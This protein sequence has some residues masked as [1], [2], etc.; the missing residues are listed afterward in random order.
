[1]SKTYTD[2][3]LPV[4]SDDIVSVVPKMNYTNIADKSKQL[5]VSH[6]SRNTNSLPQEQSTGYQLIG[7]GAAPILHQ[8]MFVPPQFQQP[9]PSMQGKYAIDGL[10][11]QQQQIPS[12]YQHIYQP[13]T[14][15]YNQSSTYV[16]PD[17]LQHSKSIQQQQPHHAT[18]IPTFKSTD[19]LIG[20]HYSV[21]CSHVKEGPKSF[22]VQLI[23]NE[24]VLDQMMY[25]LANVP[26]N[27]LKQKPEL[28]MACVARYSEDR[29]LYRAV[30]MNIMPTDC[31]V[32]YVDYG[33]TEQVAYNDI[34][35]IPKEFL[36]HSIFAY[37]FSLNGY[38]ELGAISKQCIDH[39]QQI[40]TTDTPV[41]LFV[42]PNDSPT[43][44]Q[45]CDLHVNGQNVM[46]MLKEKL[47]ERPTYPSAIPLIE[48][49]FVVIRYIES[50]KKFFVQRQANIAEYD[51][52]M[53][54]F[55]AY[56]QNAPI[57]KNIS[58]GM[59]C[60][61][62]YENDQEW[63]RVEILKVIGNRA[64][65][66]VVDFGILNEMN[67][68]EL[69]AIT[70]EFLRMPRQASE[71]CLNCFEDIENLSELSRNQLEM[72][73]EDSAG[74]RRNF[75]VRLIGKLSDKIYLLNLL[76]DSSKPMLD[77]SLRMLK[78]SM[79]PKT[80]RYFEQNKFQKPQSSLPSNQQ[81]SAGGVDE[82]V[83]SHEIINSTPVNNMAP[84]VNIGS[85]RWNDTSANERNITTN[86]NNNNSRFNDRGYNPSSRRRFD[87]SDGNSSTSRDITVSSENWDSTKSG[88]KVHDTTMWDTTTKST[89]NWDTTKKT[90]N[91]DTT[92]KTENWDTTREDS[93]RNITKQQSSFNKSRSNDGNYGN[94]QS[95]WKQNNSSYNDNNRDD[96]NNRGHEYRPILPQHDST[97]YSAWSE[98]DKSSS[99]QGYGSSS[100]KKSSSS[101]QQINSFNGGSDSV[102][103]NWDNSN[104]R[105]I[106]GA[107][108]GAGAGDNNESGYGRN[109]RRSPRGDFGKR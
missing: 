88:N 68:N 41:N 51:E 17:L 89:E 25:Q 10:Y 74:D 52:M 84:P 4:Q 60:A 80:F 109:S 38:E 19:L 50:P 63:Y 29:H 59:A 3:P 28:G 31:Q 39:F 98:Q 99:S 90:E 5:I 77:L 43:F 42:T 8:Q 83:N 79:P 33:N 107:G 92:K 95:N 34:Y 15:Q 100:N 69:K 76:D 40:T 105:D 67:V 44:M 12:S 73:A 93:R 108:A 85:S 45:Y 2:A 82:Q 65:I 104:S 14:P 64:L 106:S 46:Q 30:I 53:D 11:N 86:N 13:P 32:V 102:S 91:W 20:S 36:K 55:M 94:S 78:L 26:L 103:T 23:S 70:F 18:T 24:Q 7:G 87:N 16:N 101:N 6:L 9:P 97:K 21:Y 27:N 58:V 54:K 62:A 72:L 48:N 81:Q 1:M 66:H 47:T 75:K 71:C 61:A 96:Q 37:R 57:A 35:E 49:D 56:C 22:S